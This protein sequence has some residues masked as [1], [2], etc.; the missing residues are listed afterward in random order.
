MSE[1]KIAGASKGPDYRIEQHRGGGRACL[2]SD[3]MPG[4]YCETR[5]GRIRLVAP[6]GSF[7]RLRADKADSNR[8][9]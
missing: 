3:G 6:D 7:L 1:H 2:S 4:H 5:K 9:G 8:R